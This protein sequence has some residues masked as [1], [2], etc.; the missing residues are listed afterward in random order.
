MS[1]HKS[2][3]LQSAD[4]AQ[5]R[6]I[7]GPV[8]GLDVHR[9][10]G[11]DALRAKIGAATAQTEFSIP[12]TTAPADTDTAPAAEPPAETGVA[13]SAI[14]FVSPTSGRNDPKVTLIIERSDKEGGDR[15]VP[16]GVNGT[17]ILIPRGEE[18]EIPWRYYLALRN[19]METAYASDPESGEVEERDVPSYPH[20][21]THMPPQH[22]IDAWN[23][24]QMQ[25]AG[26]VAA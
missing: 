10:A 6:Y 5:L 22:E 26:Q 23:A 19:A 16:V 14:T 11:K 8:L 1:E 17:M 12:A 18:A 2:V 20:R 15:A 9:N 25:D 4:L 13:R 3:S 7:A 21:V 24:A